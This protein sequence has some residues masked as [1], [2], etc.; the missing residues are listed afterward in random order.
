MESFRLLFLFNKTVG[1]GAYTF[2]HEA[3]RKEERVTVPIWSRSGLVLLVLHSA[4]YGYLAARN[5]YAPYVETGSTL[6]NVTGLVILQV[7][8]VSMLGALVLRLARRSLLGTIL[9]R[10]RW[11]DFQMAAL[12]VPID[13][14]GER[15]LLVVLMIICLIFVAIATFGALLLL[16]S[17]R[18]TFTIYS[19]KVYMSFSAAVLATNAF[20][21]I[22]VLYRRICF[23][24][25][26]LR[27]DLNFPALEKEREQPHHYHSSQILHTR[28]SSMALIYGDLYEL[29]GTISK[30]ISAEII[31]YCTIVLIYGILSLFAIYRA[32]LTGRY[33]I[34]ANCGMHVIWWVEYC[35]AVLLILTYGNNI[36]LGSEAV[37]S[38]LGAAITYQ[39]DEK[40]VIKIR[41][42]M[43]QMKHNPLK[44]TTWFYD[45]NLVI[46]ATMATFVFVMIQFD[47]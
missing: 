47:V 29:S 17:L 44:I 37:L 15:R 2:R 6:M 36:L 21:L 32:I 10:L 9:Q 1:Y 11:I 31:I 34:I 22:F 25:D 16:G 26:S 38:L 7:G 13:H 5:F 33:S 18:D 20:A 43:L 42:L 19:G 3:A 27:K 30:L 8:Y 46:I 35:I 39:A 41:A 23:L 24:E 45:V 28:I 4:I 14:G 12:G 40:V